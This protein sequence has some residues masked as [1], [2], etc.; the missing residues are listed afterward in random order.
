MLLMIRLMRSLFKKTPPPLPLGSLAQELWHTR[1]NRKN[2]C[3]F[4]L[5]GDARYSVELGESSLALLLNRARLFAWTELRRYRYA[6]AS[7][8]AELE[9]SSPGAAGLILRMADD[10][11]FVY[12][13]ASSSG[14]LRM[15]AVFNGEPR[16]I[17]PWIRCPWLEGAS[18]IV[19]TVVMRGGRYI[20]LANGRWAFEA[21]DDT[22]ESGSLAFA[23]QA[24][25]HENTRFALK[26]LRI[27]A[28]PLE[29]EVDFVR[30][31]RVLARD[32]AQRRRLAEVLFEAGD[33]LPAL[34]HA[35]KLT[36]AA[37]PAAPDV[38]LEAECLLRLD[39][40]AEAAAALERCLALAPDMNEARE[41]RYNLLYLN[42]DYLQLREELLADAVR[43]D[44]SPRL[45]NLLGHAHYNLGAWIPAAEAY[46][47][48]AAGDPAMPIYALNAARSLDKAGMS[49]DAA[50]SWLQAALGFFEQSAWDDAAA[51]SARLRELKY[52]AKALDSLDARLAYAR[53]DLKDAELLF[54][55]L[56]KKKALDAPCAYLYGLLRSARGE[57]DEALPLFRRAL[58]LD[59]DE[60]LYAYRLA[61]T[62][63][64]AGDTGRDFETALATALRLAPQDG[65][66]LNLAGQAEL[67]AC[68][69]AEA[70]AY[71]AAAE[72]A[73]PGSPEP[74]L[75]RS[76]ALLRQGRFEEALAALRPYAESQ[77]AAANQKGNVLAAMDRLEDAVASYGEAVA[78][79]GRKGEATRA[80]LADYLCNLGDAALRLGRLAD[81]ETALRR[82][83]ELNED[84]RALLLMGDVAQ[85]L[86][87]LVRAELAYRAALRAQE[88][89]GDTLLR[90][91]RHYLGRQRYD[92]AKRYAEQLSEFSPDSARLILDA[93]YAATTEELRCSR[94]ERLWTCPKPLGPVPRA[95]LRGEPSGDSP[96]GSCPACGAAYCVSC[97]SEGLQDGRFV[98]LSCGARL[99]LN[100]DRL[101]WIAR[102][103]LR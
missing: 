79:A 26:S 32:L 51:C 18:S 9:F 46:G 3:G 39:M 25:E 71:F 101:R 76:E 22:V 90:L 5:E 11:S 97:A 53:G 28:R 64:L 8:D 2:A 7:I 49:V 60:A 35:R 31:G 38:F 34:I 4:S 27:E 54:A 6:D 63:F 67:A 86:G 52:D 69:P 66:T 94:C 59:N 87:D 20:V 98:C 33:Y 47:R 58:E 78:L 30:F 85:E 50:G 13:L 37:N 23:A 62:L 72:A 21:D 96:A 15:D 57:R 88:D 14:A 16:P 43:L 19:L 1:F 45:L 83:L 73:L 24:Y 48:A 89:N 75:N 82:S 93:V 103:Y 80:P 12:I 84:R 36:E 77:A 61:E 40:R 68:R 74:A 81:A 92:D 91:A 70:E 65:W 55:K 56:A 17:V 41:E 44:D 95:T 99:N 102:S 42:G 100:D 29:V 10:N